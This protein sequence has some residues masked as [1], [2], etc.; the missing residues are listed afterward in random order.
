MAAPDKAETFVFLLAR[1]ER[2]VASYVLT[3]VP[4]AADADD[5]LQEAKLTMW[6]CFG[7]FTPGT[8]FAAWARKV[9]FNQ[10][11]SWRRRKQRDPLQFSE[12][13]L[14]AVADEAERGSERLEERGRRLEDCIGRLQPEHR[15]ILSL[16]YQE[17]LGIDDLA[18]RVN[19][20][21]AAVYRALSRIRAHLH[22]C[23]GA[24][25]GAGSSHGIEGLEPG[26]N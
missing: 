15:R 10:I 11:L 19:R 24:A 4:S 22:D 16:R 21:V 17:G 2:Q 13:F 14:N 23:V 8:N 5:I 20:T 6:R 26:L 18:G 25:A 3:L 7:E 9:A 12:E 1:H